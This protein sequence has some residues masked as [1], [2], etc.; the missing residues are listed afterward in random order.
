MKQ[1]SRFSKTQVG[2][3]IAVV[4]LIAAVVLYR[5]GYLQT[6]DFERAY[7][8]VRSIDSK[9]QT[10]L[11]VEQ[12]GGM[13]VPKESIVPM[14][15]ELNA[16]EKRINRS[17]RTDKTGTAKNLVLARRLMLESQ[18]DFQI[19]AKIGLRGLATDG[20]RC[21]EV[22]SIAKSRIYLRDSVGKAGAVMELL[23]LI[24]QEEEARRFLGV[25]ENKMRFYDS[26]IQNIKAELAAQK[27]ALEQCVN[28]AGMT[29]TDLERQY[30]NPLADNRTATALS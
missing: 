15:A 29:V 26:P 18:R 25:N 20:Y 23:D 6:Y 19:A 13:M 9:Y 4:L 7:G 24:V 12:L 14:L 27:N 28:E 10:V 16:I 1:Q 11:Q 30:G 22:E 2:I 21:V 3:A 5:E 8:E 17:L